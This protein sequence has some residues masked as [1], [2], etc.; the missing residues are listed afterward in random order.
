MK[1]S[2]EMVYCIHEIVLDILAWSLVQ[3]GSN[4]DG[5]HNPVTTRKI[6]N[7]DIISA[8]CFPVIGG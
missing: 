7:G 2:V 4:T 8:N 3:T 5:A 1:K 6:Q